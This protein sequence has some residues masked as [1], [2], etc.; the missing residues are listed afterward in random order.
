MLRPYTYWDVPL[1]CLLAVYLQ[2]WDD[3]S[4]FFLLPAVIN[5]GACDQIAFGQEEEGLC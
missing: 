4:S 1:F 3:P 2:N 5:P